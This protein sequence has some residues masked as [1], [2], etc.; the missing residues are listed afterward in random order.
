MIENKEVFIP[1]YMKSFKCIGP[2]CE[3]T[4][5]AGWSIPIDRETYLKYNQLIEKENNIFKG[6]LELV[7]VENNMNYART[8]TKEK[9]KC[10]FLN[11]DKLCDIQC[12]YGEE[13]L[14]ST[15]Y[16]Y[17]RVYN[18]VDGIYEKSATLSCPEAARLILLQKEEF[19]FVEDEEEISDNFNVKRIYDSL[20]YETDSIENAFFWEIRSAIIN[21]F[22]SD[23]GKLSEKISLS[24]FYINKLK[25]KW[26][27]NNHYDEIE[28]FL[29]GMNDLDFKNQIS[30]ISNN[31][32]K[33]IEYEKIISFLRELSDCSAANLRLKEKVNEILK[34]KN[35][36][37]N[38]EN[39]LK[40]SE[41]DYIYKNLIINSIFMSLYP[42]NSYD[43][44]LIGLNKILEKYYL[45]KAVASLYRESKFEN[46][47]IEFIQ[48][49]YKSY[50]H[51]VEFNKFY[52]EKISKLM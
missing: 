42:L 46:E 18:I 48:V 22:N 12:K 40:D 32:H 45:F 8:L 30:L 39:K 19:E 17:P 44:I 3:D 21:I 15:C 25:S 36:I 13:F 34:V 4:C 37:Q 47:I 6:K 35:D 10:A 9:D 41:Y 51:N 5:C 26:D 2:I 23:K 11:E 20:E 33:H 27:N 28:S 14:S 52:E 31:T 29:E 16:H 49:F 43:D 1:K 38:Y 24:R 7:N 50:E